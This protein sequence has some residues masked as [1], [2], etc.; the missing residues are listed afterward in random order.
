[1]RISQTLNGERYEAL[2]RELYESGEL[3]GQYHL[4]QDN[5]PAHRSRRVKAFLEDAS[6]PTFDWPP[7]SLDLNVIENV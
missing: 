4:A 3:N 6:V 1:M 2:L 5:A 7:M